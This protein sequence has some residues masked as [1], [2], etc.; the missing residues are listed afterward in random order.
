MMRKIPLA[1]LLLML[2]LPVISS[3]Q[4]N[5]ITRTGSLPQDSVATSDPFDASMDSLGAAFD[6]LEAALD[7][8]KNTPGLGCC[9]G[10]CCLSVLIVVAI[11]VVII[12]IIVKKG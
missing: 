11:I 7:S 3:L 8:L 1:I 9:V 12:I 5:K 10:F 4:G 2:L 6:T